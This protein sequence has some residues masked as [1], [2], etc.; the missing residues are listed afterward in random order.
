[1]E[2]DWSAQDFEKELVT[3]DVTRE[4]IDP[5]SFN[6]GNNPEFLMGKRYKI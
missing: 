6:F 4:T 1:M 2:S 3:F 5:S